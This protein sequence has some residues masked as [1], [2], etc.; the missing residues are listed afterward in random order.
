MPRRPPPTALRLIDGP[1]P[2]RGKSKFTLPS[3]PRPTFHPPSTVA[4]GPVPRSREVTSVI[5]ANAV[6]SP[7]SQP[8]H[9]PIPSPVSTGRASPSPSLQ[10]SKL[11]RGPWDHSRSISVPFDVESVL[12]P[13]KRVAV[14][15]GSVQ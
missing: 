14:S 5:T 7:Q 13:P 15:S 2:A 12:A 9:L 11:T 10:S 8:S 6:T 1:L 4:R 3:I